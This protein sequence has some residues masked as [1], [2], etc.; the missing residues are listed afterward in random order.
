MDDYKLC[1]FPKYSD[2]ANFMVCKVDLIARFSITNAPFLNKRFT[3]Q[4]VKL[5]YF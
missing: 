2:H 4:T 3:L 1:I 5:R